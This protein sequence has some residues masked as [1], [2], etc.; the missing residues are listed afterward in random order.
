[1]LRKRSLLAGY[2]LSPESVL[3]QLYVVRHIYDGAANVKHFLY[4]SLCSVG[5]F[6][7]VHWIVLLDMIIMMALVA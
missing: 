6:S 5:T 2:G 7:V 4:S 3:I 1:M